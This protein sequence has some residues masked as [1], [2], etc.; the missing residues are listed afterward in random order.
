MFLELRMVSKVYG[1]FAAVQNFDLK[2][3][4]GELI[5]LLGPSGCGKSTTI[6]MIGGFIPPTQGRIILDSRD[7][8]ELP[9]NMRPTSTVFQNYALFPHMSVIKNVVYGLKFAGISRKKAR[10]KGKKYLD[11]VGLAEL[12]DHKVTRLS[13]GEQQRV[14]LIRSLVL[15]PKVLLL[16]EP[17]SNLDAKLRVG[18]RR[19]IKQIQSRTGITM[20][21]VTH[22]QEEAL[23]LADR[24][25]VMNE[26]RIEQTGPPEEIYKNP[27][28]EFVTSFLGRANFFKNKNGVHEIF[29]PEELRLSTNEKGECRGKVIQRQFSG[30]IVT[31]F[32]RSESGEL[33][34]ADMLSPHD[35]NYDIGDSVEIVFEKKTSPPNP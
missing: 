17:L 12:C 7:I 31:Y 11:M 1:A 6:G 14:A 15:E 23:G 35:P 27:C 10:R 32:V 18:L 9:A 30:N 22:D 3:N 29:R 34:E 25:V 13:G 19:E 24:V 33:L 21:Y 2:V 20:L 28:N 16:D 26:G 4:K 8:T 5:C